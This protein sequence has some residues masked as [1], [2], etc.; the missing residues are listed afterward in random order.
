MVS[1]QLTAFGFIGIVGGGTPTDTYIVT[2][3]F[4][5]INQCTRTI[6][7][8]QNTHQELPGVFNNNLMFEWGYLTAKL[9]PRKLHIFLIG[10]STKSLPSDLSGVW[11]SEIKNV[12]KTLDQ[13]AQEVTVM[14]LKRRPARLQ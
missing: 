6:I 10:E 12:D 13:I 3:I 9:G 8:V 1:A 7:L 11:A 2:Q 14:F 4:S 5:Q